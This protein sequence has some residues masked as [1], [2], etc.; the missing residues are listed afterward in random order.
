M[1]T[2][3][4]HSTPEQSASRRLVLFGSAMIAALGIGVLLGVV[5]ADDRPTPVPS[6]DSGDGTHAHTDHS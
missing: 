4:T 3:P 6:V 2:R 1:N 5:A